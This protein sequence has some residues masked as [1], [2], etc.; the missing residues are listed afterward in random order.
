MTSIG[1]ER[2]DEYWNEVDQALARYPIAPELT[3]S[4]RRS[5]PF[6]DAYDLRFTS[7]GPYRLFGYLSLPKGDGPFPALINTPRYGS[8]N[9]PPH[10][11]D[12]QRYVV[13]TFMHRGQ[14]LADEPF[15]AAYPGL[16][17]RDIDDPQR[18]IYRAIVADCLRA[19]E[20]LVERPEVDPARIGIV[21]DDLAIITAAR[22]PTFAA[23]VVSGLLWYRLNEARLRSDAYPVE[24]IND[25]LRTYP[26]REEAVVQTLRYVDPLYH[27]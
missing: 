1:P 7:L 5:T 23:L 26:E 4:P 17:T 18:Y 10:W 19:A 8:V 14:R 15:A 22:R 11:D 3:P 24:E 16:L 2:T 12:R 6:A 20:F 9:T 21:G 13:L 25:Y 27:A